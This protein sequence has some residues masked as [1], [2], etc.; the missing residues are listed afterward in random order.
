MPFQLG[1]SGGHRH[2]RYA[3]RSDQRG[4]VDIAVDVVWPAVQQDDRRT[5]GRASLRV[6]DMQDAGI[7]V[8][9]EGKAR[10]RRRRRDFEARW[11]PEKW[12]MLRRRLGLPEAKA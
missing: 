5:L 1:N 2:S 9:E 6:S 10:A 4:H 8:T 3:G 11:T 7:E 12:A